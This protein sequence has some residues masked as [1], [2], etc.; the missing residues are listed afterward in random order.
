M[1]RLVIQTAPL[2]GGRKCGYAQG[3]LVESLPFNSA[4]V[5]LPQHWRD[6]EMKTVLGCAVIIALAV[7]N[8]AARADE[9]SDIDAGKLVGRWGTTAK[10]K[11][12]A[13]APVEEFTKDG[14]Y[15]FGAPDARL[16][17]EGTYKVAG[18]TVTIT[19]GGAEGVPP[20]SA[21]G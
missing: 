20:R 16:K 12:A 15:S 7:A 6:N 9:K 13:K 10:G 3:E 8:A 4:A 18:N 2:P 5:V 14:K 17:L 1:T 21:S 19:I 11:L